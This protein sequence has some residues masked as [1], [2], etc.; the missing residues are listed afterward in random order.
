MMKA[1]NIRSASLWNPPPILYICGH[2]FT[3]LLWNVAIF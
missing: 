2:I 3:F 1:S